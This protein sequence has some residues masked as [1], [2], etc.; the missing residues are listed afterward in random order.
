MIIDKLKETFELWGI[1]KSGYRCKDCQIACHKDCKD[2]VVMECRPHNRERSF[3]N[4]E[5]SFTNRERSFTLRDIK[6]S[7][8]KRLRDLD[9]HGSSDSV[10]NESLDSTSSGF[11]SSS[12]TSCTDFTDAMIIERL[13]ERITRLEMEKIDMKKENST[14]KSKL[15][16]A[17]K[18]VELLQSQLEQIRPLSV[19]FMLEQLER[20]STCKETD[21]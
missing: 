16:S 2:H 1:G 19:K 18:Q 21:L 17:E 20:L 12:E 11:R 10:V 15:S 4:R 14:L 8:K 13:K 7:K 3:A 6:S 5:R 9:W